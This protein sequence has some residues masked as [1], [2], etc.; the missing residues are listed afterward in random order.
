MRPAPQTGTRTTRRRLAAAL[1]LACPVLLLSGCG[2]QLR[3]ASMHALRGATVLLQVP[4]DPLGEQVRLF[5]Q[6]AGGRI[7]THA[8]AEFTIRVTSGGFHQRVVAVDPRTG[9]A[10][11]YAIDYTV[12]FSVMHKGRPALSN[13]SISLERHYLFD[14]NAAIGTGREVNVIENEMR[15]DAA[16]QIFGELDRA[17]GKR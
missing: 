14:P 17:L 1:L 2:W 11:D 3:G 5:V 6:A 15:R 13:R 10:R 12:Y 4:T 9:L 16:Q 7:V 8:P